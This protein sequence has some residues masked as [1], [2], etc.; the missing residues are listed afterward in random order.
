V[1]TG[2]SGLALAG[3]AYV[4]GAYRGTIAATEAR[5]GRQGSLIETAAGALE[6][7]VS[8]DWPPS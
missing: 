8:G 4:T 5:L 6:Y 7:A 2:L 3:G 1:L